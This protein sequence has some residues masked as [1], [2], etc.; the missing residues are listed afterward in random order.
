MHLQV[1]NRV[2]DVDVNLVENAIITTVSVSQIAKYSFLIFFKPE[3][4][5]KESK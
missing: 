2:S 1:I 3:K 4:M 5:T